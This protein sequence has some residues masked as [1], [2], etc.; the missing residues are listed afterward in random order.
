MWNSQQNDMPLTWLMLVNV[1]LLVYPLSAVPY[2]LI[3]DSSLWSCC[4]FSFNLHQ[5]YNYNNDCE[6]KDDTLVH[7]PCNKNC[8]GQ[9]QQS[10]SVLSPLIGRVYLDPRC[11]RSGPENIMFTVVVLLNLT[12]KWTALNPVIIPYSTL[13]WPKWRYYCCF[14]FFYQTSTDLSLLLH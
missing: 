9:A 13:T 2:G 4:S 6:T 11:T 10:W 12:N 5:P 14:Y 7:L 3:A 1:F 8:L